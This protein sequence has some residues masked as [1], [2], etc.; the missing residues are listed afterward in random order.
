MLFSLVLIFSFLSNNIIIIPGIIITLLKI[1]KTSEN[2]IAVSTLML[3]KENKY[4]NTASL[5]P[6]PEKEI[7]SDTA[8]VRSG[9]DNIAR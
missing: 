3:I 5:A 9:S 8:T 1:K 2:I 6:R 7:G 4:A